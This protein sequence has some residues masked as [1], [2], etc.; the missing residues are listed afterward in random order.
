MHPDT[1]AR[2]A[3]AARLV[4][5]ADSVLDVGG[6]RGGLGRFLPQSRVVVANVEPPADVVFDGRR[7]PFADSSFAAATSLDVLEH[8]PR[9]DR[10]AHVAELTRVARGRVVLATPLGSEQHAEAERAL[11]A[12]YEETTG[13]AHPRLAQHVAYGLPTG[14]ELLE[15]AD[16]AGLRGEL[17]FHGDFRRVEGLFRLAARARRN[18][19]ARGRYAVQRIATTPDVTLTRVPAPHTNRAFL[20]AE[21]REG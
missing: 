11:A 18:P 21:A 9:E 10:A 17:F 13:A 3:L 20:V 14:E 19:L 1:Y 5:D 7:L 2:H 12:W 6:L 4:G 15:L 16:R 8:L